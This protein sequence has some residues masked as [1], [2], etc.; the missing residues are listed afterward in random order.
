MEF[1]HISK[2]CGHRVWNFVCLAEVNCTAA[3]RENNRLRE[4]IWL[5][6]RTTYIMV[7]TKRIRPRCLF[8]EACI[9][10][11]SHLI[12]NEELSFR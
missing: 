12:I 2:G 5:H 10:R 4:V 3:H 9:S 8:R 7:A 11:G 1:D 6:V